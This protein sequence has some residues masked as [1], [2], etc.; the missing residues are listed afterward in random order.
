MQYKVMTSG[1][2]LCDKSE[3]ENKVNV[4]LKDLDKNN[5]KISQITC[6]TGFHDGDEREHV[7]HILYED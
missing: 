5:K 2:R 6:Q 1:T 4:F 7:I 3:F